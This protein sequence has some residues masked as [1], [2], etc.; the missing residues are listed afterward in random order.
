MVLS[1]LSIDGRLQGERPQR[2]NPDVTTGS[3]GCDFLPFGNY[4]AS[5]LRLK[6]IPSSLIV[7]LENYLS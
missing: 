1:L 7:L 4:P 3:G 2:L 6:E 5:L